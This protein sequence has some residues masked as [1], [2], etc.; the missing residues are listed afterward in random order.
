MQ[1]PVYST[2]EVSRLTRFSMRQLDY[3][4]VR[5]VVTPSVQPARGKGNRKEYA[6]EDLVQFRFI[7]RLKDQGW[8]TQKIRKAISILRDV[9]NDD[10][11]LKHAVLFDGKGTILA[12]C[13]T[14]E[15]ERILLDTLNPGG[16]QV[17]RIV[18]ETLVAEV[19]EAVYQPATHAILVEAI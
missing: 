5:G 8:S 13:K 6:L 9:M 19:T 10:D 14:Q 17:M 15:G 3:W 1:S 2:V 16:Q 11:P 7:R 4:A 18:L 12:M